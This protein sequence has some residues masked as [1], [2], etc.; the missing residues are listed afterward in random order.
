[1]PKPKKSEKR[2]STVLLDNTFWAC[3]N[4]DIANAVSHVIIHSAFLWDERMKRIEF[5]IK[6][7]I[8]R[9]ITVCIFLQVP[10]AW[11]KEG[12]LTEAERLDLSAFYK[13][14]VVLQSWGVH[15]NLKTKVHQKISVIDGKVHY[16]GSLNILSHRDTAENMR[17]FAS[18]EEADLIIELHGLDL[19]LMCNEAKNFFS[20]HNLEDSPLKRIGESIKRRR[21][22]IGLS[23]EQLASRSGLWRPQLSILEKLCNTTLSTFV[24]IVNAM[25]LEILLVPKRHALAIS[26]H[27]E[28][29]I[30]SR[31]E[32]PINPW[33]EKR[34]KDI[35]RLSPFRLYEPPSLKTS[36]NVQKE[37][38]VVLP[39]SSAPIISPT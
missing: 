22:S 29:L 34:V 17:R 25:D 18:P 20:T 33:S 26:S 4:S 31:L 11:T 30:S 38:I 24:N 16:E 8:Q 15:L 9:G 27:V 13:R 32:T 23:Q 6:S 19:C 5:R 36:P 35:Y 10:N 21:I 1:M 14:C 37:P 7:L 12:P 2:D 39:P 3:F 28:R